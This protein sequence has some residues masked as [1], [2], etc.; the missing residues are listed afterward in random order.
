MFS[1]VF[2]STDTAGVEGEGRRRSPDSNASKKKETK[3]KARAIKETRPI[4]LPFPLIDVCVNLTDPM[5]RGEYNNGKPLHESDIHEVM[6]RAA[7]AQVEGVLVVAGYLEECERALAMV[8]TLPSECSTCPKLACTVGV[9]PTRCGQ[10]EEYEDGPEA[11]FQ[12]IRDVMRRGETHVVAIGECGLDYART[13]FCG[14]ETQLK[15]FEW[16]FRLAEESGLPMLFHCRDAGKDFVDMCKKHRHRM[17]GGGLV[18]SFDGSPEE[19]RDLV[20]LG[21]FIGL[22]GCSLKTERN[23]ST[24]RTIPT[25]HIMIE[26]D[27]PWCDIRPTHAGYEFVRSRWPTRK[28]KRFEKGACVKNR[29]EPCHLRQVLEVVASTRRSGTENQG[30]LG[31][32]D[33]ERL[34]RLAKAL[35]ENT[36][37]L[38]PSL[39]SQ[40]NEHPHEKGA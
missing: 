5:F 12:K 18:H 8:K 20:D 14:R 4:K 35:H 2:F 26:T 6:K 16:Q 29:T 7:E 13:R 17:V 40:R 31:I 3:K 36:R 23:L 9:H 19:A 24:V 22:N 15:Y 28:N 30:G 39:C 37:K 25:S 38:F 1:R 21:L 27:A 32:T 10:F 33:E 34:G 11:Y